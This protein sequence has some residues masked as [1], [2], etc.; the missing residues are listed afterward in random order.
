MAAALLALG[1]LFGDIILLK[2]GGK[3]EGVI[4]H[5]KGDEV[6]VRLKYATVELDRSEIQEIIKKETPSGVA[7]AARLPR[8]DRCVEAGAKRE[9]EGK[10]QQVPALV[11]EEGPLKNVPYMS[12]RSGNYEFNLYG[13]PDAP[14]GVEIGVYKDLLKSDAAKKK[15]LETMAD[16][17]GDL[18][19]A[20]VLKG[21]G[22]KE[23]KK[24]REGFVFEITPETAP[25]AY[26]GWWISVYDTAAI[27]KARASQEELDKITAT[28][29]EMER[30]QKEAKE[31]DRKRREAEA[32]AKAIVK[33][34]NA[35]AAA[36]E[37]KRQQEEAARANAQA[38]TES[39]YENGY[40]GDEWL[41]G[42]LVWRNWNHGVRP[43]RPRP[44]PHTPRYYTPGYSRGGGG[45]RGG[46]RGGGGGR[47]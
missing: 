45:Y 31:E 40:Y 23:I 22:L 9:W 42:T 1:I 36:A 10:W 20:E 12:F 8:W 43:V 47:R 3:L 44:T 33:K 27:E 38:G 2:N 37:R 4:T 21:L 30:L 46:P 19:D 6:V 28:R 13:D 24:E 15:C 35:D 29:E 34:E 25:D 16:M 39:T 11:V 5:D 14:A 18:K 7:K 17:M 26:E 41:G 32:Q